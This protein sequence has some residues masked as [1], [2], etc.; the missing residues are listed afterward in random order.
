MK[1]ELTVGIV[2]QVSEFM[3]LPICWF[4]DPWY[5]QMTLGVSLATSKFAAVS[6]TGVMAS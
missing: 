6:L 1:G 3:T 2:S 5:Q 4:A